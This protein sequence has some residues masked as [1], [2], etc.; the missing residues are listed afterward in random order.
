MAGIGSGIRMSRRKILDF[1]LKLGIFGWLVSVL[2]PVISYLKPLP[3]SGSTGP[4]RLT[5]GEETKLGTDKFTIVPVGS[6]RL[7]VFEDPAGKVRALDAKCTHEG[8]TV[9]YVPGE[10]VIWCPCHNGRYD[11]QGRVLSGPPPRPLAQH[12][13][14]VDSDGT[15]VVA[16][17]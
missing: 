15:I 5:R 7:I 9:T 14:Q 3:Q 12:T 13:V 1:L 10:S 11:L 4:V 8:C 2:Y 17:A 16:T 6:K